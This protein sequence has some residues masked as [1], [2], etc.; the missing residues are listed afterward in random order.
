[1]CN[2]QNIRLRV[3]AS[4]GS[5]SNDSTPQSSP[6]RARAFSKEESHER[7]Q[8]QFATP[9]FSTKCVF[10]PPS[11][12]YWRI[13]N[14]WYDFS[15]FNHPGGKQVIE[16]V[17][18]RFEDATFA[19]EAHH[20]NIYK[21]RKIIQKYLL[22]DQAA[23][24]RAALKRPNRDDRGFPQVTHHDKHLD[25]NQHPKLM[26]NDVFYSVLRKRVAKYLIDNKC[27]NGEPTWACMAFFWSIFT[28]WFT[29][30]SLTY[31]TGSYLTA[32]VTGIVGTWLASFGHNWVHQPKYKD[33]G[34]A[35]LSLD[36]VGLSSEVWFRDHVLHHHM[37]TNTPWDHH[38]TALDPFILQD[39]TLER[40]WLQKYMGPLTLHG[41]FA[42]GTY[43]AFGL[44]I[45][46]YFKGEEV[47]SIGKLI[48]PLQHVLFYQ[49]WGLQGLLLMFIMTATT[50]NYFY[51]IAFMNHNA[52]HCMDM[53]A[54]NAS[55]DWG[56]AQLRSSADFGTNLNFYQSMFT[57]ILLNYHTV[58]HLFPKVDFCHHAEIS[59]IMQATAKEFDIPYRCGNAWDI[60]KE[61]YQCFME[62]RALFQEVLVYA[63]S[64]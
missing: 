24:E 8:Q 64:I 11:E 18:D 44:Q 40:N 13:G 42:I 50:G 60:Y 34:F 56:E 63:G 43:S 58:H 26:P 51:T 5:S 3:N 33:R 16:L 19:F 53:P 54:R 57:Y 9:T 17:R 52:E 6:P 49:A 30:M 27:P 32:F 38:T 31:M 15:K 62:P 48:F 25:A 47:L 39:Q 37:Y 28:G 10:Y 21:A 61:M 1:M 12:K 14:Q 23:A 2:E 20:H 59:K 45:V 55:K 4:T 46:Q 7:Q 41:L 29:L 36:M 35:I 22:Q